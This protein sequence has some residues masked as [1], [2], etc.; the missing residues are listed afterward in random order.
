MRRTVPAGTPEEDRSRIVE[1]PDGFY[2]Q[3]EDRSTE[4]GPFPTL[5][6]AVSDMQSAGAGDSDSDYE[7]GETLAEAEDEIGISAWIDPDTGEP[8]EESIPRTED[9]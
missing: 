5:L 8:A 3:S 9:H 7:P 2:W 4:Y 1:R 6:E